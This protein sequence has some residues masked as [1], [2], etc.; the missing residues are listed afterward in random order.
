MSVRSGSVVIA[1]VVV[2]AWACK[3]SGEAGGG[4]D[5]AFRIEAAPVTVAAGAKADAL[6]KFVPGP[7]LHWN[8]EFPA[9]VQV[10]DPGSL[11]VDKTQFTPGDFQEQGGAGVLGIPVSGKAAGEGRLVA[12]ADF[13]MCTAKECRIFKGIP[14]EVPI[15]VQ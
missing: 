7:G 13:S 1:M 2:A 9:K 4:G 5:G 12:K 6:V 14:I 8:T 10:T 3:G 11:Q 15:H